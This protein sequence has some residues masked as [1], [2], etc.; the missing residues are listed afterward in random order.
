MWSIMGTTCVSGICVHAWSELGK[1]DLTCLAS[2][3]GDVLA[4]LVCFTYC[5]EY[6]I[7]KSEGEYTVVYSA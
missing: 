6:I 5:Q 2:Y 7:V 3:P 4:G 1:Q